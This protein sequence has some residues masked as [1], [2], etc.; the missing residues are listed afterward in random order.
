[1][2]TN[3]EINHPASFTPIKMADKSFLKGF[4]L[5]IVV[6]LAILIIGGAVTQKE[7]FVSAKAHE[8]FSQAK[9]LLEAKAGKPSFSEYKMNVPGADA[10]QY[11]DVKKLWKK[12]EFTPEKIDG[13]L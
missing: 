5:G 13:V 9:P 6:M 4:A 3:A 2:E 8:V 1:M 7:N 11:D 10:V 12:G